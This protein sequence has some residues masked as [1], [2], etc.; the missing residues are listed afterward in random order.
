MPD[1][2][3]TGPDGLS[4]LHIVRQYAPS[5]GGMQNY[6]RDLVRE[7]RHRHRVTVLTLNRTFGSKEILPPAE[8]I[9]GCPVVR[10]PFVGF[11]RFFIPRY[12]TSFLNS[13][14]LIHIHGVDGFLDRLASPGSG[15]KPPFVLT[16]HGLFFH[17]KAYHRIKKVYLAQITRPRLRRA[18]EIFSISANDQEIVASVGL[19]SVLLHNP[20][21]PLPAVAGLGDD[22]LYVGRIA[23][24][25][26]VDVLLRFFAEVAKDRPEGVLHVVGRDPDGQLPALQSLAGELGIADR[27][28]FHGQ[29]ADDALIET[30]GQCRYAISASCFEGFG[31]AIVEGMSA[32]LL[33]VVHDNAAFREIVERSGVGLLADFD[34]P[35][36]AAADFC[37]WALAQ[38]RTAH[39]K[40]RAF[41][42][43]HS[44]AEVADVVDR[45]YRRVLANHKAANGTS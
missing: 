45:S 5:T 19:E 34:D 35:A 7:Q 14:D 21:T 10:I 39:D 13:F 15:L 9:E 30:A 23:E 17:T 2:F 20:V 32:G 25:K 8:E 38:D 4:I 1:A 44:W 6:V 12:D 18:E 33:P 27:V 31:L 24:N 29:L 43:S 37:S 26:Q 42:L 28:R 36:R 40:A 16:T 11:R 3:A 22:F 41:A